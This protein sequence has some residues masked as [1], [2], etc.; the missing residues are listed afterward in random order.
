MLDLLT[1]EEP[2]QKKFKK[3]K[4]IN[5]VILEKI[6]EMARLHLSQAQ[7]HNNLGISH[8]KWYELKRENPEIEQVIE[9][10]ESLTIKKVANVMLTA[11]LEGNI[12]AAKFILERK[13]GWQ[14][15]DKFI[16]VPPPDV[17][18]ELILSDDPGE[19]ARQYK[20]IMQGS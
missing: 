15:K 7:M 6:A 5:P 9:H 1:S 10:N 8:T 18:K 16:Q 2:T 19:A 3:H 14:S 17:L 20:K 13:G 11:A 4:K 12:R